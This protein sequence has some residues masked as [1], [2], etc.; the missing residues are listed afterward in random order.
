MKLHFGHLLGLS[1][2]SIAGCAAFFSVY[3]ISQLFAGAFFAVVIMASALEFGKLVAASYLQR[4]W[5]KIAVGMRIYVVTGVVV[6]VGVTSA[7][8]Y[9]FLSNAY[10]QTA[11][12]LSVNDAKV[13]NITLKKNRY[14]EELNSYTVER[15]QLSATV[16]ELSKGLA[17][18]V[19]Q[20]TNKAG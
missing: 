15:A 16:N 19:I 5:K 20:Y 7:G 3:G 12:A 18:N 17:N 11:D 13:K 1:A 6:L 10:Q 9:G 2:L 4:Y 14:D 8:I